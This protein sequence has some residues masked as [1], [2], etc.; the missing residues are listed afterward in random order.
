M[1]GPHGLSAHADWRLVP[2]GMSAHA[3]RS[4]SPAW[5]V[6][7]C[8]EALEARGWPW[9]LEG[10]SFFIIVFT[11]VIFIF[12]LQLFPGLCVLM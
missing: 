4:V 1:V 12:V 8:C 2:H 5:V 9:R 10:S 3:E 11:F 7:A 6:S